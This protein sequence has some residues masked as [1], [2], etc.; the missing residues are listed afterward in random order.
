M[1]HQIQKHDPVIVIL[2]QNRLKL[3]RENGLKPPFPRLVFACF[4]VKRLYSRGLILI[5]IEIIII[6]R[7]K[8]K[9]PSGV[10]HHSACYVLV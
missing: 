4:E 5:L 8:R 3:P 1:E 2:L 10:L 6:C 9:A 7:S